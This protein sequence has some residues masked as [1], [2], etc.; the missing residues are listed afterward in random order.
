MNDDDSDVA[1]APEEPSLLDRLKREV[2]EL[3]LQI[4]LGKAEAEDYIEEHKGEFSGFLGKVRETVESGGEFGAKK[5]KAI[6]QKLDE[7]RLQLALGKMET[8][9]AYAEQKE[10]IG[11]AVEALKEE[12]EPLAER[13]GGIWQKVKEKFEVGSEALKT[14]IDALGLQMGLATAELGEEWELKKEQLGEE[15][16]DLS[17]RLHDAGGAA[18]GKMGDVAE[19]LS[20]TFSKLKARLKDLF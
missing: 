1:P 3:R 2:D 4:H 6:R 14:K 18:K 7:L 10:K 19:E 13:A 11:G 17:I 15:L 16:R 12:L 5:G 20:G 9:D 8:R